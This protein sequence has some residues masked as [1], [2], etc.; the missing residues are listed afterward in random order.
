MSSK[1]KKNRA[2]QYLMLLTVAGL[3]AIV[4]GSSSGTFASFN[5]EVSNTGNYFA[6]GTLVLNDNGGTTTCTSAADSGNLNNLSTN[7]CDTLFKVGPVTS[8]TGTL[9]TPLT[10]TATTTL[11]FTGLTGGSIDYGDTLTLNDGAGHTDTFTAAAGADPSATSIAVVSKTP[12]FAFPATTTTIT[13]ATSTQY[14]KLTLTNAG[15]LG[16]NGIKFDVPS[17]CSTT[18]NEGESSGLTTALTLGNSVTSLSFAGLTGGGYA[19]GDPIVV[20]EGS[21][22]QTFIASSAVAVGA[23]TVNV[24]AQDANFS[25][26]TSATV[27]GPEF[28][29]AGDL[30][31]DLKLSVV[32]TDSSFNHG[33]TPAEGCAYGTTG[34]S[35]GLGC[36]IGS[37]TALASIPASPTALTLAS[38]INS[39]TG[40]NLSAGKSRYF[41]VAVKQTSSSLD[42][43]YQNRKATFDLLWHLDQA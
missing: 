10:L 31:T 2:K 36:I 39:N 37:G 32:E 20:K 22:S 30:C 43:T 15:T 38:G 14:A 11:A 3:I 18:F 24:Q 27:S 17:A 21:H 9:T 23:T 42:N 33:S 16:A 12:N 25:Y 34:G 41:L 4:G 7:G 5:A 35:A 6:T 1:P 40:T 29:P 19:I 28:T 13:D 8:V 26:T